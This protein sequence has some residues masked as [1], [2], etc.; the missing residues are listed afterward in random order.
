MQHAQ[1]MIF[2]NFRVT[3]AEIAQRLGVN[4]ALSSGERFV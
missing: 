3:V 1:A 2:R 4:V